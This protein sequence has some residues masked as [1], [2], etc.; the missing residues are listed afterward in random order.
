MLSEDSDDAKIKFIDMNVGLITT[1]CL[2]DT[3]MMIESSMG[4]NNYVGFKPN[5]WCVDAGCVVDDGKN[6]NFVSSG[7][8][9]QSFEM[10]SESDCK[11]LM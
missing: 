11:M 5:N 10:I 4:D 8:E 7:N 6:I 3:H 9:D 2:E 1:N